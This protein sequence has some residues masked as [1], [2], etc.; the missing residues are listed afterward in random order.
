M[1]MRLFA[2]ILGFFVFIIDSASKWWVSNT[3][4]LHYYPVLDGLF[5]IHYVRNEGIAFG[6]F[7]TLESTWKPIVLSLM[8]VIAVAIVLYYVWHTPDEE[9]RVF[10]SLGLLL[11]GILGNFVDRLFHGYVID[12]LEFHWQDSFSWPT[13]NIA[14]AAITTGVVLI[15]FESFFG[16]QQHAEQETEKALAD[17]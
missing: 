12:F 8:A 16:R 14:D 13:F 5:T 3:L 2:I 7:H 4:A 15:I 1:R 11:G 17:E 6:L 9:R 10:V